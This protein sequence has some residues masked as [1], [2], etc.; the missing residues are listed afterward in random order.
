MAV[1]CGYGGSGITL[2]HPSGNYSN[3]SL[4][5]KYVYQIRGGTSPFGPYRE[6][7]V[8]TADGAQ[9]IT[10]GVDDFVGAST[11]QVSS[12]ITGSYQVANDGTGFITLNGTAL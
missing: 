5:G 3:A 1:G 12:N 6:F 10:S 11:G 4:N 2:P 7:G 8:L 9:H